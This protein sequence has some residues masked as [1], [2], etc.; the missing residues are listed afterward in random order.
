LWGLEL[1]T[2]NDPKKYNK[3]IHYGKSKAS[4][5]L[6]TRGLAKRLEEKGV[7][8][9]YVNSIDPG[10]V[11][12]DL[13]RH[14]TYVATFLKFVLVEPEEGALTHLYLATSPE[15]EKKSIKGK[16]YVPIAVPGKVHG[17][18]GSENAP[19][20]LWEFTENL[21]KEKVPT[22]EGTPI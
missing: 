11:R 6:F 22:Y 15:V 9:I 14:A 5:I 2:I 17:V 20:K 16:Y 7:H 18:A 13:Q 10:G 12:T 1:E 4:N 21:L 8:N 3:Y 19:A